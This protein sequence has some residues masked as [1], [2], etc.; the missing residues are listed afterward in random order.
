VKLR[1]IPHMRLLFLLGGLLAASCG[2]N[3]STPSDDDD[4]N[5]SDDASSDDFAPDDSDGNPDDGADSG[6]GDGDG[7]ADGS[8]LDAGVDAGSDGDGFPGALSECSGG[9]IDRLQSWQAT[10][11]GTMGPDSGSIL[12]QDGDDWVGQ[13]E[14]LD[15]EWHVVPVLTKNKFDDQADFSAS[16]GFWLTYSATSS[17]YVQ[18][19]PGFAWN[20]GDKYLTEIPSTGGAVERH[21][22]SFDEG[23]WTTLSALGTPGYPYSQAIAAVRGFVF[24]GET[25]NELAFH[26]LRVDGFEPPCL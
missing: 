6:D 26:G 17:F 14:W 25:P 16:S 12:V 22:F 5:S 21:F 8:E 1:I 7:D 18:L 3:P 9:S 2:D 11:E 4:Q 15:N 13:V 23:S 19:R 20:G 24:V 10:H